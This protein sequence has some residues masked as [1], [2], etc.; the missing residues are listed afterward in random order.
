MLIPAIEADVLDQSIAHN[1]VRERLDHVYWAIPN[2]VLWQKL[3]EK[4]TG[5]R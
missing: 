4:T 5:S 1:E 2:G 3:D